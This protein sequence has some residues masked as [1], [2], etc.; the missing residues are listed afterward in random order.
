MVRSNKAR[1]AYWPTESEALC[2]RRHFMSGSRE[3]L[4]ATGVVSTSV[5]LGK[6]CDRNPSVY[7]TRQSDRPIVLEMPLNESLQPE[8]ANDRRR[9]C[10]KVS[11]A[12]GN[13]LWSSTPRTQRRKERYGEL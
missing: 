11:L 10:R 9:W 2:M 3:S 5:R 4:D 8:T 12:E 13:S 1:V 7:A 6:V